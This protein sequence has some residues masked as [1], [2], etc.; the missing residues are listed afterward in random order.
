ML[1][2]A[3][4]PLLATDSPAATADTVPAFD[5]IFTIVME[6]HSY[7][8]II[9]NTAEAPYINNLADRYGLATEYS[10][11]SHPSLPNY[12][13]LAGGETFGVTNDCMTCFVNAPTLADRIEASGRRWKAYLE[14]MPSP[15]FVG[16]YGRYA[17]RH[18]PFI[19]FDAIRT[20]P[21]ECAR[22]VPYGDLA[23]DLASASQ[24]PEYVWITPD[25]C[26]DMH[27]CSIRAG[28]DW[29]AQVVPAL[30]SAPA[31]T[32]Q[33]SLLVITW[34]EDEGT[35]DNHIATLVI[36][37]DVP[38]GFRSAV[39]HDHY[40]LLKTVEESWGLAPLSANDGNAQ[41]LDEFFN[42]AASAPC[43][44][45]PDVAALHDLAP[46]PCR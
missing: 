12:L 28:D 20:N 6:N 10:G 21:T 9:G 15:C 43:I 17:Q 35:P 18:N 3:L 30:L 22:L 39:R 14:G 8:D 27:D 4:A 25:V 34:D 41:G 24:T 33:Q 23:G 36:A 19:Y 2:C 26:N 13:A 40:S 37:S 16:N 38:A 32:T 42:S 31:F 5:H 7:S 29:L 44:Y 11:V 1:L 45:V 46:R